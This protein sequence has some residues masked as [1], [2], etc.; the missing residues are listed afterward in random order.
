MN[1]E[2]VYEYCVNCKHWRRDHGLGV[3]LCDL[4][5]EIISIFH[6]C[7]KFEG[8]GPKEMPVLSGDTDE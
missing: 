8:M 7:E 2:R 3:V 5:Q 6:F 4:T 1:N